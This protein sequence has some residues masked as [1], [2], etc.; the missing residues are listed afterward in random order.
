MCATE[1]SNDLATQVCYDVVGK[2]RLVPTSTELEKKNVL[3]N[4]QAQLQDKGEDHVDLSILKKRVDRLLCRNILSFCDDQETKMRESSYLRGSIA[5]SITL[6]LLANQ[7]IA[8]YSSTH[9]HQLTSRFMGLFQYA[10]KDYK[11]LADKTIDLNKISIKTW[12]KFLVRHK[13]NNAESAVERAIKSSFDSLTPT[14][15]I[16]ELRILQLV[17]DQATTRSKSQQQMLADAVQC[18]QVWFLC[19]PG[20]VEL[21]VAT[22]K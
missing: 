15:S 14:V 11:D 6:T 7:L 18:L 10:S 2:S 8:D 3:E 22:G 21:N 16:A 1:Q 12:K 4:I 13:L 20:V 19:L 17:R 5:E 9:W